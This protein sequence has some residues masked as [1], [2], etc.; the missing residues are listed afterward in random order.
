MMASLGSSAACGLASIYDGVTAEI[1]VDPADA[2]ELPGAGRT[3]RYGCA[4]F[5]AEVGRGVLEA[6]R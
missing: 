2:A 5:E 3:H 6:V 1:L 4:G